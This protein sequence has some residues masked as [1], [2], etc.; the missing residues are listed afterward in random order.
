MSQTCENCNCNS[1]MNNYAYQET[2][3]FSLAQ[4]FAND[5]GRS[6]ATKFI[7][8]IMSFFGSALFITAIISNLFFSKDIENILEEILFFISLG[9]TLLGVKNI[10]SGKKVSYDSTK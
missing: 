4:I 7:G 8:V 5:N 9:T 2:K 1:Q 10:F 6:S 3:K